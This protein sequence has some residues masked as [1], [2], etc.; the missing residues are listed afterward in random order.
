MNVLILSFSTVDDIFEPV[1]WHHQRRP[2]IRAL[3]CKTGKTHRGVAGGASSDDQVSPV[4]VRRGER[5]RVFSEKNELPFLY[6]LCAICLFYP[7][8]AQGSM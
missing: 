4:F 2:F 7:C 3:S 6:P 8:Q 5:E 1:T